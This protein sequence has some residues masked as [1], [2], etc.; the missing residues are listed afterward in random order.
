MDSAN[1]QF[2]AC[3]FGIGDK[4]QEI[5]QYVSLE[6]KELI[7]YFQQYRKDKTDL[8]EGN[9]SPML[10]VLSFKENQDNP[11][12]DILNQDLIFL[13]GSQ[14]DPLF[15]STRDKWISGNKCSFLFTLV[16]SGNG[17]FGRHHP[18]SNNESIIC[19]EENDSE[20]QITKFV[21][22]MCRVWMFPRLLSCDFSC[23]NNVLS[24]TKGKHLSFKSKIADCLPSF[25]QFLSDNIET[26]QR[27][28]GIFY[29]LSS[30]LGNDFSIRKHLQ[31]VIDEIENAANGECT[32]IGSDSLYA[33]R[34]A[35]FRVTMICGEK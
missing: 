13:L 1:G 2:K 7:K 10:A 35:P 11:A 34:E 28:S 16:L 20:K 5:G 14:Q 23:M 31:P 9:E 6:F 8:F 3:F 19:F 15:W 4:G 18:P 33:E 32:V 30:N 29:I 12:Q 27:A 22:D 25:R 26:T 24:N 17:A 21:K